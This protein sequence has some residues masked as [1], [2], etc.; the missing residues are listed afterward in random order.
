MIYTWRCKGCG[1]TVEV[2]RPV[3]EYLSP[4]QGDEAQHDGC[5]S[6]RFQKLV[7]RPA[8]IF[9]PENEDQYWKGR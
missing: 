9:I 5:T 3:S 7:T 2:L 6:L 1:Q 4:P 8:R